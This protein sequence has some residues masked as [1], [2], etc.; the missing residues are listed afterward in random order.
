MLNLSAREASEAQSITVRRASQSV[1][2]P[3]RYVATLGNLIVCE[4]PN[5]AR[6]Y[7]TERHGV[8]TVSAS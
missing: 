6:V 1:G 8:I 2:I 7:V 5:R 4:T 3:L